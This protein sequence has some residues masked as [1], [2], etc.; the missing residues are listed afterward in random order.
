MVALVTGAASGIGRASAL[1]FAAQGATVVAADIDDG[2]GAETVDLISGAGAKA[3]FVHADVSLSGD[4]KSMVAYTLDLFGRLDY[5]HNNAGIE[6][7]PAAMADVSEDDWDRMMAVN[8]KSVFLCMKQEI[9]PMVRAGRGAIVNTASGAGLGG[10]AYGSSYSASKHGVV[11]L[12]R[13]ASLDYAAT[14]I[15]INALCPGV[16]RTPTLLRFIEGLGVDESAFAAMSPLGRMAAPEE[17]ARAAVWL[18]SDDASYMNGAA[19]AIDGGQT[20]KV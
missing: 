5:A 15:R 8:L 7:A 12:T 16:V 20:A 13:S 14:G 1:A 18:C 2:Q 17:I 19:L 11:G 3:V 10:A 4:V 6:P 9:P